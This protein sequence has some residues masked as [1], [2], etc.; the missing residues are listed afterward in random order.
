M[1]LFIISSPKMGY[2][3]DKIP[4]THWFPMSTTFRP[5]S[6]SPWQAPLSS[7]FSGLAGYANHVLADARIF[8]LVTLALVYLGASFVLR[9]A[10]FVVFVHQSTVLSLLRAIALG[11]VNDLVLLNALLAPLFLYLF[12]PPPSWHRSW[13]GRVLLALT[14]WIAFFSLLFLM[15]AQFY[16]FKEFNA[17]FNLVAVDYLLYPH[18][19]VGNIL[20]SYHVIV[21]AVLMAVYASIMLLLVAKK[22]VLAMIPD[23]YFSRRIR[24]SGLYAASVVVLQ[25]LFSTHGFD[26]SENRIINEITADGISSF[27]EAFHTN[28]L[29]YEAFYRTG[30]LH[31]LATLLDHKLAADIS[32]S[33]VNNASYSRFTLTPSKYAVHINAF[34][35]LLN[36]PRWAILDNLF[37]LHQYF[38]GRSD[39][40]S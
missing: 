29:D 35:K 33:K 8:T 38:F 28:Q 31:K 6:R 13:P 12:L 24:L 17:R 16:F 14:L 22:V 4:S 21:I 20:A 37:I 26:F 9:L 32:R 2:G 39:D 25:C 18:E 5:S 15:V 34:R 27:F 36:R 11:A 3:K 40:F 10:L 23:Q 30:D 1:I 19:V 7:L